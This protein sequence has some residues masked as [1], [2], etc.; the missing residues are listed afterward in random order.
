VDDNPMQNNIGLPFKN[1]LVSHTLSCVDVTKRTIVVRPFVL[2]IKQGSTLFEVTL[3]NIS[4]Q[5]ALSPASR[6]EG[7]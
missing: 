1:F 3:V 5:T 6:G 4:I 2:S 7:G